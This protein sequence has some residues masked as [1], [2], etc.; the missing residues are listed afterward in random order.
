[1]SV[2]R[3]D[4]VKYFEANGYSLM[5]EGKK[6]AIYSNG[7]RTVPIKRE[8]TIDRITANQLCK[9]AGLEPKF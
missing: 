2:K 8:R 9:Q 1:M 5:R 3:R 4:L 6:H 7:P